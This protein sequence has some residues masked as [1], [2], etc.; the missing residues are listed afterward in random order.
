[1]A[2]ILGTSRYVELTD[3]V[4]SGN[5][6]P[7]PCVSFPADFTVSSVYTRETPPHASAQHPASAL[8]TVTWTPQV[9]LLLGHR[10]LMAEMNMN[11]TS[12]NA[13]LGN[14]ATLKDKVA[15][16]TGG[17][18]GLG[19]AICQAYAAAGAYI[20]S[21]DIDPNVP[22]QSAIQAKIGKVRKDSGSDFVTPT[23]ELVNRL[24]PLPTPS[25]S[26]EKDQ[27][28]NGG[29]ERAMFVKCD[30]SQEEDVKHAVEACVSRYGRLDIMV[31]NAGISAETT[32]KTYTGVRTRT[33]ETDISILDR[34]LSINIR[35]VWLGT[36]YAVRQFLTQT[37]HPLWGYSPYYDASN[38]TSA[39]LDASDASD[40][41]ADDK[42]DK[43]E[44]DNIPSGGPS[45]P[46][47]NNNSTSTEIHRGW[48]INTASILSSV[49]LPGSTTYCLSKGAVLQLTRS[50]ALEYS[51][52]GIHINAIQPGFVD[53]HILESMYQ[54]GGGVGVGGAAVVDQHLKSLHP[55]G[56]TGR[57]EEIARMAVFLAGEGASWI[58]GTGMVVDGGYLAQ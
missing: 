13:Y 9:G 38:N 52:D 1:M 37:P 14:I 55:W 54:H 27:T 51:R 49:G 39:S 15:L 25:P 40:A 36:K 5:S 17:S 33:H 7:R 35:G 11:T 20:V 8:L 6:Q 23:V 28:R 10:S 3:S 43:N 45:G 24:W 19:R 58:T 21:A 32:A 56:R 31:N 48:I 2:Q 18:S 50:T 12:T 57:P 42:N 46:S 44:N 22:A 16:V 47:D 26:S 29:V 30:V 41:S 4:S 34:S 53:T